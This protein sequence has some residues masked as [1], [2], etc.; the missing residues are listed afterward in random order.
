MRRPVGRRRPAAER[1]RAAGRAAE[2]CR[3]LPVG[4]EEGAGAM[5]R[6]A[7]SAVRAN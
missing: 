4:M 3:P 1:G 5:G 2:P 7:G 6:G